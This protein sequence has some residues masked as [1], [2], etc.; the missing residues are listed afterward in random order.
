MFSQVQTPGRRV[1]GPPPELI[2]PVSGGAGLMETTSNAGDW[3]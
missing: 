2:L 3:A 1:P